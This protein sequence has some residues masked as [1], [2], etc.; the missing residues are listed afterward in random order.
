[1]AQKLTEG[2][3]R[4]QW[5]DGNQWVIHG[6]FQIMGIADPMIVD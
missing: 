4:R 5:P 2:A 3:D 1:M 6:T